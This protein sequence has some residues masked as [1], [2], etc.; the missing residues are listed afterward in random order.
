VGR[1]VSR[2][3]G[4]EMGGES[5]ERGRKGLEAAR[6]R[7]DVDTFGGMGENGGAKREVRR[8]RDWKGMLWDRGGEWDKGGGDEA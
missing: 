6:I 1:G 2:V 8:E 5:R 4:S 7:V 3:D